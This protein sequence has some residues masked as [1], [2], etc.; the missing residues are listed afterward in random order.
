MTR[1]LFR[2]GREE[3]RSRSTARRA[4]FRQFPRDDHVAHPLLKASKPREVTLRPLFFVATA[5]FCLTFSALAF[6][7]GSHHSGGGSSSSDGP[8]IRWEKVDSGAATDAGADASRVTADASVD[9]SA[10][11]ASFDADA[12]DAD[13]DADANGLDGGSSVTPPPSSDLH[14]GETCVE[15]AGLFGCAMSAA[16]SASGNHGDASAMAVGA[17]GLAFAAMARARRRRG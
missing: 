16:R 1:A 17:L 6:A 11:D 14:V 2:A 4:E 5:S 12:A 15:H 13:A 7:N 10:S 9:A 3:G 8:C